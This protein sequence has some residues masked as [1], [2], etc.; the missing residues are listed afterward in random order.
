MDMPPET[1]APSTAAPAP[2]G[3]A[4]KFFTIWIGQI[5]SLVGSALV[6]FALVWWLTQQTGS[7]TILATS[8]L[9]AL[10]PQIV[11][12]PFVGALVDRWNRRLIMIVADTAIAAVTGVLIFLFASGLVQVW[13]IFVILFL[14]SLGGAFHSP[15]MTA[16]TSLMVPHEHLTRIAGL[17]QLLQGFLSIF[18]PPL[19]A[20]LITLMPTQGVLAIDI[21]TAALAVLPLLF[22]P[23]PQPPR[24]VAQ[25]N[26]EAPQTS[27]WHDLRAGFSYVTRW[28][29]LLGLILLA[30]LLNFLLSPSSALL[31]LLVMRDYHGGAP[32]LGWVESAFGV[33]VILGGLTLSAWGGFKRRIVT[34]FMGIVG[35]G[36]GII[37]TGL[38]PASMFWLLLVAS[39]IIG[40][41]QVMANG[42]LGAIFQSTIEPDY[43]GRVFSLIGAGATAMMPLSLLIAGPISDWLGVRVW[44]VVGGVTAILA[45]MIAATIPAIMNIEQ[46]KLPA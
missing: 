13:H 25:A 8:T 45:I 4:T 39:F 36:L 21:V 2:T 15:A 43:Q 19:G 11:L 26:G 27:Y 44:Y 9:V 28:P 46:N 38:A 23:I 3:W 17:N 22:V 24:Q 42:P 33:G 12:G 30:M 29:G 7:A 10:L 32:E 20:L 34:S 1:P 31:P 6:Q 18:A 37:L 35:L 5:F 41:M 14:R 40:V 16:S